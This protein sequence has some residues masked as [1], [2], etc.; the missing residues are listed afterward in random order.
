MVGVRGGGVAVHVK[1]GAA[2]DVVV[3]DVGEGVSVSSIF[4]EVAVGS[5]LPGRQAVRIRTR[6]KNECL[7]SMTS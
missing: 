4:V 3:R 5:G 6:T 1:V 2:V 7:N